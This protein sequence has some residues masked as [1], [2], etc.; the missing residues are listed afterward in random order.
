MIL[1][2]TYKLVFQIVSQTPEMGDSLEHHSQV[3]RI[4]H[5]CL[6]LFFT[7][8]A[9]PALHPPHP[10]LESIISLNR[11]AGHVDDYAGALPSA[12]ILYLDKV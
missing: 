9:L 10:S 5:G 3:L 11:P 1:N 8:P 6:G 4:G 7:T 12:R 2:T